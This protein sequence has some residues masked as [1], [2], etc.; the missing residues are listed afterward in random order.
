MVMTWNSLLGSGQ[1]MQKR[2]LFTVIRKSDMNADTMGQL[3]SIFAWS[4][5]ALLAGKWPREDW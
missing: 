4:C 3:L 2:F 1:T 5:N